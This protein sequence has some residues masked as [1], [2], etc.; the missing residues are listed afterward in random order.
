M[1][2][3][4]LP[5]EDTDIMAH[6]TELRKAVESEPLFG[7]PISVSVLSEQ[8]TGN[9]GFLPKIEN[10]Q[11][12]FAR[13]RR[14]RPDGNCFYRSFLFGM[15]EQLALHPDR[16][17]VFVSRAKATLDLCIQAGYERMVIEDFYEDF[18][19]CVDMLSGKK[20]GQDVDMGSADTSAGKGAL[21]EQIFADFDGCLVCWARCICSAFLRQRQED[22]LAFLTNYSSMQAFC[23]KEVDPMNTEADHLQITALSTYFEFPVRV[24]YLDQSD[25][26]MPAEHAFEGAGASASAMSPVYLLYRPGHYDLLY[27]K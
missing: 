20:D 19:S 1:E 11:K 15:F 13:F 10:M 21:V 7:Q 24:L 17:Q 9:A 26:E 5:P 22:Y 18:M 8:Y 23:A 6:E 3:V 12:R 14:T 25:G 16:L 2:D 4:E 27:A